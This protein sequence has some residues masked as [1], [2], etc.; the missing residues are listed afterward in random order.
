MTEMEE[1][2]MQ[3]IM[4]FIYWLVEAEELPI[5]KALRQIL[6]DKQKKLQLLQVSSNYNYQPLF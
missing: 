2:L 4:T 6:V 3:E 1:P 5:S